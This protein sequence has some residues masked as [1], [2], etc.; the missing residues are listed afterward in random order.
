[1]AKK[2]T[3][4]ARPCPAASRGYIYFAAMKS[5]CKEYRGAP[6]RKVLGTKYKNGS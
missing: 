2:K 1:M 6:R 5:Y 3:P 4:Q